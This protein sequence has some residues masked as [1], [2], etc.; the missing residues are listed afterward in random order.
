MKNRK[1]KKI[2]EIKIKIILFFV[3]GALGINFKRLM[4]MNFLRMYNGDCF[5]IDK[6]E[7]SYTGKLQ[8]Y[9]SFGSR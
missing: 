8:R 9:H 4:F 3:L 5:L 6:L 2:S 1:S 7:I